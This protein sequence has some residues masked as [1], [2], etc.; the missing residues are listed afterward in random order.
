MPL[1]TICQQVP[2][3]KA[4]AANA[5]HA[6]A[7]AATAANA[8]AKPVRTTTHPQ[9]TQHLPQL[10]HL[11]PLLRMVD[12]PVLLLHC[13]PFHREAGYLAQVFSH[14]YVDAGLA[15]HNLGARAPALLAELAATLG[16]RLDL[17]PVG[18]PGARAPVQAAVADVRRLVAGDHGLLDALEGLGYGTGIGSGWWFNEQ[19]YVGSHGSTGE[20]VLHDGDEV[21]I[22]KYRLT[23]LQ[24]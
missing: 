21:Q 19:I 24:R 2:T 6:T 20:R 4:M 12:S 14:V 7:M 13:Y 3:P 5:A 9:P 8:M 22:G 10:L 11:L 16:E 17:G 18:P 23:F 15:T 1:L